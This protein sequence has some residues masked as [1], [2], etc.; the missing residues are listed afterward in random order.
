[1]KMRSAHRRNLGLV[2]GLLALVAWPAAAQTVATPNNHL[3]WIEIGQSVAQ[4]SSAIYNSYLDTAS[5]GVPVAGVACVVGSPATDSSCQ[6][7]LPVLTLG[8]HTVVL[9]QVISGAESAKSA[10]PLSFTF[11]VVVQPTSLR[12]AKLLGFYRG[13]VLSSRGR[14]AYGRI[15]IRP[16]R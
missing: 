5:T 7:N 8:L 10:P 16:V 11:V 3:A 1:M 9:S 15:Q 6:S 2:V 4:A 13:G 12:I 14:H